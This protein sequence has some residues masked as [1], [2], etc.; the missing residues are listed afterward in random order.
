MK[1]IDFDDN[2]GAV[3]DKHGAGK[4]GFTNGT[5]TDPST[6]TIPQDYWFDQVQEEIASV[7][8]LTGGTLDEGNL[9]QLYEAISRRCLVKNEYVTNE[10]VSPIQWTDFLSNA[11]GDNIARMSDDSVGGDTYRLIFRSATNT[12]NYV[13]LFAYNLGWAVSTNCYRNGSDTSWVR[14]I[15]K[16][17]CALIQLQTS[18]LGIGPA[19]GMF[20]DPDTGSGNFQ[21]TNTAYTSWENFVFLTKQRVRGKVV[22]VP[23]DTA[24]LILG[25]TGIA[26]AT[27]SNS[28]SGLITVTFGAFTSQ[29][30]NVQATLVGQGA[31]GYAV[32]VASVSP[33][34][35]VLFAYH[36]GLSGTAG[37]P[38]DL[39]SNSVNVCLEITDY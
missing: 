5:P 27:S 15:G 31:V 18:D 4:D 38:I 34:S 12:G 2:I 17:Y 26:T 19:I 8:E 14:D 9:Q 16:S 28:A 10:L 30:Y 11:G 29:H 36:T 20:K 1:R 32:E 22:T 13:R 25:N 21:W 23:G 7:I 35:V 24:T 3:E 33:S 39:S 6:G 37:S